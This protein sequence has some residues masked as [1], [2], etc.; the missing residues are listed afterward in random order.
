MSEKRAGADVIIGAAENITRQPAGWLNDGKKQEL[1]RLLIL[2]CVAR[3]GE[4]FGDRT[5][6]VVEAT[7]MAGCSIQPAFDCKDPISEFLM[8]QLGSYHAL[9]EVLGR[10]GQGKIWRVFTC[11]DSGCDGVHIA[12]DEIYQEM[13]EDVQNA[14]AEIGIMKRMLRGIPLIGDALSGAPTP[15]IH[16][17]A[18]AWPVGRDT[19]NDAI[20][21]EDAERDDTDPTL[22]RASGN[23]HTICP[24]C[25]QSECM[26][27]EP[28]SGTPHDPNVDGDDKPPSPSEEGEAA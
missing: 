10:V 12:V 6:E 22:G 19:A 16:L 25:E 5:R 9:A 23:A 17:I 26:C 21:G 28:A 13:M 14:A 2:Q 15:S 27:G 4:D 8:E 11:S 3:T 24:N 18:T 20:N 7:A 1:A